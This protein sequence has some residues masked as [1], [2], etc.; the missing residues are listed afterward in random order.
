M[1]RTHKGIGLLVAL[2]A[3]TSCSLLGTGSPQEDA[4]MAAGA[5]LDYA[6]SEGYEQ[7]GELETAQATFDLS[8]SSGGSGA[9]A[10]TEESQIFEYAERTVTVTRSLDDQE[11]ATPTDDV[12]TVT[13]RTD[14]GFEA[15]SIEVVVRPLRPTT[16]PVWTSYDLGDGVQGWGEPVMNQID[17]S[18]TVERLLDSVQLASGT[19]EAT[20]SLVPATELIYAQRIVKETSDSVR[21]DLIRRTTIT[22]TAS[23][24]SSLLRERV[25]DG[26]VVHSYTVGTYKDPDTG[27]EFPMVVRDDGS[28]AVIRAGGNRAGEPR[29]A[30]HFNS[31]GVRVARVVETRSAGTGVMVS[32]RTF[33]DAGGSVTGTHTVTYSINYR[34]GEEDSVTITRVAGGR[35][36]TVT[37]TESGDVYLATIRGTSYRIRVVGVT[38]VEFIDDNGA[39]FMSA[40]QQADG[41]WTVVNGAS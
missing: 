23:G 40:E 36:R 24:E 11:T 17:Q 27:T 31:D 7:V 33:Y 25:V 15:D 39:V 26:S 6:A 18:G 20:W 37:I 14:Y 30:D 29:I 16:D 1:R 10:I 22:Q 13:R 35:Q 3:V 28:F 19:I 41:S 4:V 34:R 8:S 2:A 32:T 5:V 9:R 21:T 38:T 12:L